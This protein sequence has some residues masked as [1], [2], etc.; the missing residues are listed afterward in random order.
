MTVKHPQYAYFGAA[1]IDD[2]TFIEIPKVLIEAD[3]YKTL[4]LI[5]KIIYSVILNV[6][7]SF[8]EEAGWIDEKGRNYVA[9]T[10]TE[11]GCKAGI[12]ESTVKR[13]LKELESFSDGR[14]IERMRR[15]QGNPD[16]IYPKNVFRQAGSIEMPFYRFPKVL[17]SDARFKDLT[18]T[19]KM[20]YSV[21][22]DRVSLS[23]KNQ[24]FDDQNRVY[25]FFS[26]EQASSLIGI[27]PSTTKRAMAELEAFGT[28]GLL[29]RVRQGQG[30][31]S[32]IY[33]K[34]VFL[35]KN[36]TVE[37]KTLDIS[38]DT[39]KMD[40]PH[41]EDANRSV[42]KSQNDL[43]RETKMEPLE[44]SKEAPNNNTL[45]DTHS[46][47]Q[48]IISREDCENAK[49]SIRERLQIDQLILDHADD[50]KLYEGAFM[51]VISVHFNKAADI[52]IGKHE[53]YPTVQVQT[54]FALLGPK[55]IEYVVESLKSVAGQ[56]RNKRQY[57]LAALYHAPETQG[58]DVAN[59]NRAKKPAFNCFKQN[60]YDFNDLEKKLI[61]N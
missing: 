46:K 2:F 9:M 28:G 59:K 16:W 4:T 15:G 22:L 18:I 54:R 13:S 11:I 30:K 34:S 20:L 32:I 36:E 55:D 5:S 56:I 8:S 57:M 47:L 21:M 24:W 60:D 23:H 44:R 58:V 37:E 33:V 7:M 10:H 14:L 51:E 49:R 29:E 40:D 35:K 26:V 6:M 42:K 25:I 61:S 31:P 45:N 17:L 19:A 27:N 43:S 41:T 38:Q 50:A 48:S 53:I 52:R 3:T 1:G 12:S 39:R